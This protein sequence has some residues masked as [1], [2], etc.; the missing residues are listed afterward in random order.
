MANIFHIIFIVK[1][2]YAIIHAL[3]LPYITGIVYIPF[4]LSPIESRISNNISFTNEPKN[5]VLD[6]IANLLYASLD[7]EMVF[8]DNPLKYKENATKLA[9]DT[10]LINGIRLKIGVYI[11][12]VTIAI[13]ISNCK[14]TGKNLNVNTSVINNNADTAIMALLFEIS[15]VISGLVGLFILSV[16]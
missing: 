1:N 5:T 12:I 2:E 6:A 9:H 14:F 15:P 8:V 11:I 3:L 16:S 7:I 13:C 10:F 4:A